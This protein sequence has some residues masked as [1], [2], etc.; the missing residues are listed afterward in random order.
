MRV[1]IPHKHLRVLRVPADLFSYGD[2]MF[3]QWSP[4]ETG[5]FMGITTRTFALEVFYRSFLYRVQVS[6]VFIMNY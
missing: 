3:Y 6:G 1:P 4:G 5:Q 2:P